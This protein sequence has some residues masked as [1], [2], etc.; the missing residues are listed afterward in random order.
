MNH[1]MG[2]YQEQIKQGDIVTAYRGLMDYIM[3]L[4]N[5]LTARHP[6][7]TV[8]AI[9]P[10][11]LDMTYFAFTPIDLKERKLKVAIVF[12]HETCR[13]EIWL[14]AQN[15]E[16]QNRYR[17]L[18]LANGALDSEGNQYYITP[19]GKGVDSILEQVLVEKPDFDQPDLLTAQIEEGALNFIRNI[20]NHFQGNR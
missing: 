14:A 10:G 1:E 4:R 12:L 8:S 19:E 5:E 11:Y 20:Q 7:Y 17:Q 18:F 15:K 2:V 13:W 6:D 16:I 9:Y 3:G